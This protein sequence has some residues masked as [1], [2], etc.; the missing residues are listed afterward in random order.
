MANDNSEKVD[1]APLMSWS[2]CDGSRCVSPLKDISES[3]EGKGQ[4]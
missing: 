4:W 1:L 2:S 3:Y